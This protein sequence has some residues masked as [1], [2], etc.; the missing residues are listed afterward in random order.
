MR[1]NID[2]GIFKGD[3]EG[4]IADARYKYIAAELSPALTWP[5]DRGDI[6]RSA[7]IDKILTHKYLGIPI[8][9]VIMLGIFHLLFSGNFL[10]LGVFLKD[11]DNPILGSGGLNS[12]GTMLAELMNLGTEKLGELFLSVLPPDKWYTGLIVDG[13]LGGVFAVLSFL[14]QILLLFLALSILEDSGY[15]ARAAFLLDRAFRRLGLSGRAFMP[16]LMCF[17]CGVPGIM[18]SKSLENL[19]ERRRTIFLAP[20]MSCGAKLPIWVAFAGAFAAHRGMNAEFIVMFAYL[21]GIV[22]AIISAFV[23]KKTLIKGEPSTFL[24]ELPDYRKPQLNNTIAHLWDKLKHYLLRAGTI[25]AAATV[26]LWFLTNFNFKFQM[27]EPSESI[28]GVISRGIKYIFYPLGFAFGEN[29]WKFVVAVFTGLIAKELVVAVLGMFG[30]V[31]DVEASGSEMLLFPM[32]MTIGGT[33]F[34]LDITVPAMLAFIA[35][36]LLCV[37][38]MAAVAAARSELNDRRWLW[39]AIGFWL[40]TPYVVSLVI[41]WGGTLVTL[42]FK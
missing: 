22:V 18:A 17:G 20:F 27:G 38:C 8:F 7:K 6:K 4:L 13:I 5:K 9:I 29:G 30:G 15:M 2:T 41:F 1:K 21:L 33:V 42:I 31:S 35:F 23:L 26:V 39:K 24:M 11:L 32:L 40:V 34:G 25:I 28:I 10:F 3:F 19:D 16:L 12:P 36:N 14:P 37:P